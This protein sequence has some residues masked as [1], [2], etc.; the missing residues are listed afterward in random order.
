MK[1]FQGKV[2]IS[3]SLSL[4]LTVK[5]CIHGTMA[6][7]GFEGLA[8]VEVAVGTRRVLVREAA[9]QIGHLSRFARAENSANQ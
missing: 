7:E 9:K 1:Q 2:P 4:D 8:G 6:F 3:R 5:G